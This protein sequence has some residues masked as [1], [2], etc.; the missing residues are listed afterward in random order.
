MRRTRRNPSRPKAGARHAGVWIGQEGFRP[1]D[2]MQRRERSVGQASSS[3]LFKENAMADTDPAKPGDE[4]P[5]G[6]PG[7]GEN[8]CRHC[9]GTGKIDAGTCPECQGTGKITTG[10]GGG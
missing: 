1:N 8:L 5:P 10:I 7:T 4:A 9:A 3:H 2:E 6:A